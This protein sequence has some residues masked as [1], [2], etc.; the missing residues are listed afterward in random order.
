MNVHFFKVLSN[1]EGQRLD[2]YLALKNIVSTRSQIQK[3]IEK[4]KV[5]VNG[6]SEKSSYRIRFQDTIS[7]EVPPPQKS[8]IEPK[9]IPIEILYE[10]E[11]LIVVNKPAGMVVHPGAGHKEETL[12]H[13]LLFHCQNLSGIG[14]VLR[15]GIVHRLDKDTS[16][17]MVV[18]KND[19][20]HLNL[21]EQFKQRTIQREYK[22]LVFGRMKEKEGSFDQPIGRHHHHR[23]KMSS[24]SRRGKEAMTLWKVLKE[25]DQM[26]LIQAKLK[27]GRTHQIRVHFSEAGYP[28]VG[29]A[30]YGHKNRIKNM[31]DIK[32]RH[33]IEKLPAMLLHAETLAFDHPKTGKKLSFETPLPAYFENIL[34]VLNE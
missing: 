26:S 20:A 10:D 25:Y 30:T 1:E 6:F 24:K 32:L 19:E 28:V 9:N 33:M 16:G 12:I 15:P 18:A 27:T 5:K 7:V 23:K 22:T 21:S 3:L 11:D 17:V 29:D 2:A 8:F 31:I 13:A 14:G 34:K 4:E